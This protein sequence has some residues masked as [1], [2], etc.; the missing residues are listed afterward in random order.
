MAK[1][2]WQMDDIVQPS[3]MNQIGQEINEALSKA[4]A[5]ETPAGAQDKADAAAAAGIAA[6]GAVQDNL[7]NHAGRTDNPHTVTKAQVGLGSV[8]N[9]PASSQ[10]QAEA[11]S[12]NAA[13]MTPLRTKQYVD[14]RLLNN[15]QLRINSGQLEYYDGTGWRPVSTSPIKSIQTGET[16]TSPNSTVNVT[17]SPVDI[18]KSII[19]LSSLLGFSTNITLITVKLTS[20][21]NLAVIH[22]GINTSYTVHWQVIEYA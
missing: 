13:L 12:S 2:D 20:P 1:T 22:S 15:L 18:S 21:S 3:D 10:A 11:G 5:A 8:P 14:K 19:I 4:N 17:I 7:D 9:Y 16:Q 6:A